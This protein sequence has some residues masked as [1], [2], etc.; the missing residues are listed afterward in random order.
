[1]IGTGYRIDKGD[2][3]GKSNRRK[4]V[5]PKSKA[6][7]FRRLAVECERQAALATEE[8]HF[9]ELQNKRAKSYAALADNEDWLNGS[10]QGRAELALAMPDDTMEA[11]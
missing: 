10:S 1:V 2:A 9:R 7:H 6:E 11:A 5:M 8:P 4:S 3:R